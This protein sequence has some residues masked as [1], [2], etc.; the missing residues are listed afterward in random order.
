M[1]ASIEIAP[2]TAPSASAPKNDLFTH[3]LLSFGIALGLAAEVGTAPDWVFMSLFRLLQVSL[4]TGR[5]STDFT[6]LRTSILTAAV[7]LPRAER[8]R[9]ATNLSV[10]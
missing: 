3:L 2:I 9:L 10:L 7:R 5:H 4:D 1:A 6:V 8:P